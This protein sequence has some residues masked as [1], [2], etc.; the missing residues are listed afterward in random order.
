MPVMDGWEFLRRQRSDRIWRT[1]PTF[2][3]TGLTDAE[4][5]R[6]ELG[7]ARV[8]Q[9]PLNYEELLA[10]LRVELDRTWADTRSTP[11]DRTPE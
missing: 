10:A 3:I 11:I 7:G 5:R 9:K 8:F 6:G 4:Q 1:I 2:V